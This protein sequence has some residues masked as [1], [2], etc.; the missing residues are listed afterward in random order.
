VKRTV[1]FRPAAEQELREAFDWYEQRRVGLGGQFEEEVDR[2]VARVQDNPLAF[3]RVHGPLHRALMRR[4][5]YALFYLIV[6]NKI[7]IVSVF[8][9]RRDPK[10]WQSRR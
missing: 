8:H 10:I 2:T 7:I 9:G 5:P 1:I 4:F 3:P 6:P